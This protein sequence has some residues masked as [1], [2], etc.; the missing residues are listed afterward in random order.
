L[1]LSRIFLFFPAPPEKFSVAISKSSQSAQRKPR[2]K[3]KDKKIQKSIMGKKDE[4]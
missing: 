4:G 2:Q 3:T 1:D